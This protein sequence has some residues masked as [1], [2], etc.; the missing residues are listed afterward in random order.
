MSNTYDDQNQQMANLPLQPIQPVQP[1]QPQTNSWM[2]WIRNNK[3]LVVII[4]IILAALIWWFLIRKKDGSHANVNIS[5]PPSG[6]IT[7]PA[8]GTA[9][10]VNKMRG[11]MF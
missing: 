4:I 6:T 11:G 8:T 1:V 9:I 5:M 10:K 2:D 7:T 3:V